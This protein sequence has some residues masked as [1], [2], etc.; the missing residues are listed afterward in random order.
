[1][2]AINAELNF[3]ALGLVV[4]AVCAVVTLGWMIVNAISWSIQAK[5]IAEERK[6]HL[7]IEGKRQ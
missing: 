7:W 6:I 5:R 2:Q 1:M 3:I 4:C